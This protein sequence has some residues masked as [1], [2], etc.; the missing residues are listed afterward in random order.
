M[1]IMKN[2][3]NRGDVCHNS[4][5]GRLAPEITTVSNPKIKPARAAIN[6]IPNKLAVDEVDAAGAAAPVS[7][8]TC[9]AVVFV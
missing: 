4:L 5:I 1:D 9:I 8:E 3:W 7:K 6:E 2:P